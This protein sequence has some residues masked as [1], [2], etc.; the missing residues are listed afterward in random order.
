ML[1]GTEFYP[2]AYRGARDGV[3]IEVE[4]FPEP[5][6]RH[7]PNA[8]AGYVGGQL[9]GYLGRGPAAEY[10]PLVR[11]ANALGYRVIV[12]GA[13]ERPGAGQPMAAT[14]QMPEPRDFANWLAQPPEVRA[15]GFGA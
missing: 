1:V 14:A 3:A 11:Q 2:A 6:N 7:D 5:G 9:A 10:Q 13:F 15:R 4:L 8:V 12:A